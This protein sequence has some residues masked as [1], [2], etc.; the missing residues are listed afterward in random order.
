M[1][2]TRDKKRQGEFYTP[3]KW[4]DKAHNMIASSYGED[5]KERFTVWDCACGFMNLTNGYNFKELYSSTLH[6]ADIKQSTLQSKGHI[7]F[8]LDFLN[9]DGQVMYDKVPKQLHDALSL[10]K[11]ILVFINPPYA[12]ANDK[13]ATSSHKSGTAKTWI[14][15][16]M[17]E[18]GWGQSSQQLYAQ[19]LYR[20]NAIK[21][22]YKLTNMH[23]AVFSPPLFLTG[24][25]FKPFRERFFRNFRITDGILFPASEF[26][27]VSS[28]W[29]ISFTLMEPG[30]DER[31]SWTYKVIS[32]A[33]SIIEDSKEIYNTDQVKAASEWVREEIKGIKANKNVPQFTSA[34]KWKNEGKT[35]RGSIIDGAIGYF[36][37]AS[38]N[39]YENSSQ[40]TIYTA[41]ASKGNGFS[42]TPDNIEKVC[43]LFAAR[44]TH[45]GHYA[46]WKNQKDEY[47]AP[48]IDCVLYQ[49]YQADA[50]VY[51][52]FH[53]SSQQSSISGI[54]NGKPFDIR[55]E[56]F[57]GQPNMTQLAD[58]VDKKPTL[59]LRLLNQNESK[60]SKNAKDVLKFANDLL[61][62]TEYKRM[63]YA[64]MHPELHI[65]R[66]DAGYAQLKG[67]WKEVNPKSFQQLQASYRKL[68]DEL[69]IMTYE[70]GFLKR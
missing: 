35:M 7:A 56:F 27:D 13:G 2:K 23:I 65:H 34:V 17:L 10:N 48:N 60:M 20:L 1:S 18:N 52:L 63:E 41:A 6:E 12:T 29:G 9:D 64:S 43:A 8:Q 19:F 59:M 4:V 51:A 32:S 24:A 21:E 25:S 14:N 16:Q 57:W 66:W 55:N 3:Q 28:E 69:R 54:H 58:S 44:K 15:D 50:M 30:K 62:W 47:L 39:I 46:N 45:T 38:N 68:E 49:H 36:L 40:V 42:I 61:Y 5:W 26:M 11:P 31:N 70:V 67:L 22:V 33:D 53:S 37:N